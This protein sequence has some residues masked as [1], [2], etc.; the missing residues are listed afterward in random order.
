MDPPPPSSDKPALLDECKKLLLLPRHVD[1]SVELRFCPDADLPR[2]RGFLLGAEPVTVDGLC[3]FTRCGAEELPRLVQTAPCKYS[4]AKRLLLIQ[5]KI[6][7]YAYL[8]ATGE[9]RP[10]LG[11]PISVLEERQD[12]V[13]PLTLLAVRNFFRFQAGAADKMSPKEVMDAVAGLLKCPVSQ[14]I[15]EGRCSVDDLYN[16]FYQY[17]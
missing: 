5:S 15:E 12:S 4:N 16:E 9:K 3:R 6:A 13:Q 7:Y 11:N 8:E 2:L 14:L 1:A 17:Q 10:A